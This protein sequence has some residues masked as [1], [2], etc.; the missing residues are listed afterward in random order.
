MKMAEATHNEGKKLRFWASPDKPEVWQFL[1]DSHVD[2]VNTDSLP[3]FK[4]YMAK[5]KN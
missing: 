4:N 5:R 1:L 3:K 2:L